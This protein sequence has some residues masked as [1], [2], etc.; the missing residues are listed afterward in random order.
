M[1]SSCRHRL[2]QSLR[3]AT[4]RRLSPTGRRKR[5]PLQAELDAV[6]EHLAAVVGERDRALT[7]RDQERERL[8]QARQDH[9]A[10]VKRLQA[11]LDGFTARLANLA[12]DAHRAGAAEAELTN[13][14][15]EMDRLRRRGW[16]A[17]LMNT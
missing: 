12:K 2:P 3:S 11:Q 4:V 17:R 7:E 13:A 5:P 10:E 15:A 14:R 6:R 1:R 8:E 9:A 16:L